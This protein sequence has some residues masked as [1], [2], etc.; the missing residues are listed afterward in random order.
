MKVKSKRTN[1]TFAVIIPRFEDIF[2]SYYAG[3]I[4]KGVGLAASRLKIDML[5]HITDRYEHRDWL[6]LSKLEDELIEGILFADINSDVDMLNKVINQGI[7]YVVLNNAFKEPINC[8]AI[9]NEK[10]G[11]E[12]TEH[13]IKLGHR[14]IATITG[15][16]ST[17]AGYYRLEGYKRALVDNG[18]AVKEEYITVGDFLR[19]PSRQ[20]AKKLLGLKNR[21]TAIFAA[22]DV[23]A[24]ELIDEAKKE[25][26]NVPND[27]SVVGFDD[28]PVRMYSPVRLSTVSQPIVEMGRLG[29]EH[30]NQIAIKKEKLPLKIL[31]PTKFIQRESTKVLAAA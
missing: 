30:L 12:V 2:H 15:E 8:I 10:A 26:I 22:S 20:A 21:P 24:L 11:Y 3:E 18:I 25:A 1:R 29:L 19:T 4:L 28:N 23:M 16:L 9:D 5:V 6:Q 14:N 13:L 7:P 31:L 17:Q 27:L